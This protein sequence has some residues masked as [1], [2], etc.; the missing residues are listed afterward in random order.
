MLLIIKEITSMELVDEQEEDTGLV[1]YT[2]KY[3]SDKEPKSHPLA[4]VSCTLIKLTSI[5]DWHQTNI[6][7]TYTKCNGITYKVVIDGGSSLKLVSRMIIVKF[8]LNMET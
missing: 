3:Y 5:K 4:I 2:T 1:A 6:F 8:N 7:Y